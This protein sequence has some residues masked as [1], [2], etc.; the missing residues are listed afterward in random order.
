MSLLAGYPAEEGGGGGG[1]GRAGWVVTEKLGRGVRPAS[2][3]SYHIFDQNY[4]IAYPIYDL[5]KTLLMA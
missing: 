4:D 1:G 5:T 3:H 2:Q